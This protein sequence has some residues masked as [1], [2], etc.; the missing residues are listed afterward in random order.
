MFRKQFGLIA[1][2]EEALKEQCVFVTQVH[3]EACFTA[4]KS[5]EALHR[6]LALNPFFNFP[7][8]HFLDHVQKM[9]KHLLYFSQE[10]VAVSF[11]DGAISFETKQHIVAKLQDED[12]EQVF[13]EKTL[14]STWFSKRLIIS[15]FRD[16]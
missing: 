12:D 9:S 10:L 11:F 15:R 13:L 6:D 4:C 5:I 8:K 2:K 7:T 1:Q 3:I 16:C 14:T